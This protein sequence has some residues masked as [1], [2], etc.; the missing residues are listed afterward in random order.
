MTPIRRLITLPAVALLLSGCA[1]AHTAIS[2][3]DL[4]VQTK[5]SKSIFL[6]PV[7]PSEKT[8]YLDV[9]N[10]TDRPDFTISGRLKKAIE[11]K[12][13]RVIQNPEKAKFWLQANILKVGKTHPEAAD[14]ALA[15]GYGDMAIATGAGAAAGYH[16]GNG[17][18]G[19]AVAGGLVG[20]TAATVANAAV[21]DVTYSI[22]T[23]VQISRRT[24][25]DIK[26]TEKTKQNLTQGTSGTRQVTATETTDMKRYQTRIIST[27]NKVNLE[28][29]K[30][31]PELVDGLVHSIS[32]I[33]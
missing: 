6:D 12:G 15:D 16:L 23:D 29:K 13:Y 31:E 24:D 20:A 11:K 1:A 7:K 17:S 14:K 4:E 9:S 26:V 8:V 27:A 19:G 30:A 21:E 33:L 28:F 32:G 18:G 3:S 22:V 10:T 5:M 2:K 25:E